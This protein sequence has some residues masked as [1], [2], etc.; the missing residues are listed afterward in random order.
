MKTL[1]LKYSKWLPFKG[2]YAITLFGNCV[3]REKY[4]NKP[5]GKYTNNHELI[6][7]YQAYDFINSDFLNNVFGYIIFYILYGLEWFFKA[8]ISLFTLFKVQAYKSISFEQEAYNNERNLNYLYNRKR[9]SW[10]QYIFKLVWK[11]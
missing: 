9:F 2:F 7:V 3:R 10:K 5:L 11:S 8:I 4:R 6:H 1:K